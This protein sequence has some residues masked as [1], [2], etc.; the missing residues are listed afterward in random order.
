MLGPKGAGELAE[1]RDRLGTERV[2][3]PRAAPLAFDPARVAEDLEVM[4]DRRLADVAAGG[5]VAGADLGDSRSAGGGSRVGSGRP[6]PGGAGRRDRSGASSRSNVLTDVYIVK[7][8]YSNHGPP[9]PRSTHAMTTETIH[10]TVRQHYADAAVRASQGSSCCSDPETIG[11]NLYSALERDE[12]PDAAVL[13]SLG[14]GNPTAVADLHPGRARPRPRLRR[15]HRRPPLGQAGRADRPGVRRRHDRRDAGAGAGERRPGRR[16]ERRVPEGPHRGA[17][18]ARRVDRRRHQ[19]LRR[20]PRRRQA[21]GL[22]RDRP[23][24]APGR[25]DRDQRHRGGGLAQPRA[26]RRARLLRR[27]HRGRPVG[28]RVPR[29]PAGGR[30]DRRLDHAVP[31]GRRRDDQRDHQGDEAGRCSTAHRSLG[32]AR[33]APGRRGRR[34]CGGAGCC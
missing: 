12:L 19:Q 28:L 30:P 31:H 11:A 13:A 32:A 29:G 25:P 1:A 8:Q 23:R 2:P 18:A 20:Q 33:D 22:R 27:L 3:D 26:A 10:E 14:C 5:E 24:P 34:C 17:A 9:A 6:Q 21:R 15:R 7:Y 4:R 16:D